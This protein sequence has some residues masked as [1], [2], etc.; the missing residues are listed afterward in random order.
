MTEYVL[1]GNTILYDHIAGVQ[2]PEGW[3]PFLLEEQQALKDLAAK[4]GHLPSGQPSAG[5]VVFL[6]VLLVPCALWR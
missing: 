1:P 3:E 4:G 2:M 6:R 5:L